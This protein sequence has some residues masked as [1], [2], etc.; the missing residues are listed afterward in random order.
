MRLL[1]FIDRE[2][3]RIEGI[4]LFLFLLAMILLA[5]AQVVARNFFDTG[6]LWADA[7][8]RALILWVGLLGAVLATQKGQHLTIDILTKFLPPAC[9]KALGILL[10]VFATVVCLYLLQDAIHFVETEKSVGSH[11]FENVPHWVVELVI[12]ITFALMPFHFLVSALND[13]LEFLGGK[14]NA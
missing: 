9:R 5:F 6:I 3:A 11:F 2:L 12:P 13:C 1:N 10:K 14:R 7:V 4:C 8:V